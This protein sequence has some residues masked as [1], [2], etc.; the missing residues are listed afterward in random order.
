MQALVPTGAIVQICEVND[1][2]F[3]VRHVWRVSFF[4]PQT[5]AVDVAKSVTPFFFVVCD[6]VKHIGEVRAIVSIVFQMQDGSVIALF[7]VIFHS[8]GQFT[9][10]LIVIIETFVNAMSQQGAIQCTGTPT[11]I[12]PQVG[13]E[14]VHLLH[15]FNLVGSIGEH[16][17]QYHCSQTDVVVYFFHG[18]L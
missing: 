5:T 2:Q 6:D 7:A 8:Y 11:H 16:L 14:R 13:Q 15:T 17:V 1:K 18:L 12:L 4:V 9:F 10:H 3:L